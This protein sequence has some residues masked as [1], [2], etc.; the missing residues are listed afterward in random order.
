MGKVRKKRF[1]HRHD[2]T[3]EGVQSSL[4]ERPSAL[5]PG[6]VQVTIQSEIGKVP[7]TEK[8]PLA[9]C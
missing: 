5:L 6:G 7:V 1:R 4:V 9:C 2:P 3:S 8:V